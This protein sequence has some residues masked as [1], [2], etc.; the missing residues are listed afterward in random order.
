MSLVEPYGECGKQSLTY[1]DSSVQYSAARCEMECNVKNFVNKCQ[2]KDFY[3]PGTSITVV[4]IKT[5]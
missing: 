4:R 3:M 1:Y 2:C 5:R